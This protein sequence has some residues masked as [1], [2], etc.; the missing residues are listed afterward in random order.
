MALRG[1]Q[2]AS[3]LENWHLCQKEEDEL[4]QLSLL[5]PKSGTSITIKWPKY[6]MSLG[7]QHNLINHFCM[8]V[9]CI[10][11]HPYFRYIILVEDWMVMNI[12]ALKGS[13]LWIQIKD[14]GKIS[15]RSVVEEH[16]LFVGAAQTTNRDAQS[17]GCSEVAS[18]T[19]PWPGVSWVI[20]C[21]LVVLEGWWCLGSHSE[22]DQGTLWDGRD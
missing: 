13:S 15:R 4:W 16:L 9:Y 10:S 5:S 18:T 3:I 19:C 1:D 22:R 12:W 20:I 7:I 6:A 8:A 17:G 21:S 2:A 14:P 11:N